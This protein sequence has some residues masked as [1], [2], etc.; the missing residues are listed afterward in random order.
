LKAGVDMVVEFRE[1]LAPY[2][3]EPFVNNL[4]NG[5]VAKKEK[6]KGI[7]ENKTQYQAQIDYIKSKM[8]DEKKGF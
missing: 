5:M 1:V 4:L 3:L 6:A 2:G 8:S 7:S